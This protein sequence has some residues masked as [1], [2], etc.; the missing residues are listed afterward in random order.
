ME[1]KTSPLSELIP[2][3]PRLSTQPDSLGQ[4]PLFYAVQRDESGA[5]DLAEKLVTVGIDPAQI[6]QFGQTAL[7]YAA[8]AGNVNVG[9]WLVSRGCQLQRRDIYGQTPLF[10]AAR[11]GREKWIRDQLLGAGTELPSQMASHRPVGFEP[12][13]HHE[14]DYPQ[15]LPSDSTGQTPLFYAAREGHIGCVR[16]L[17]EKFPG[18]VLHADTGARTAAWF[19]K[20]RGWEEVV[21]LLESAEKQMRAMLGVSQ[22]G[23]ESHLIH[24]GEHAHALPF[25]VTQTGVPLYRCRLVQTE[26]LAEFESTH[27]GIAQWPKNG[28]SAKRVEQSPV[29]GSISRT[30]RLPVPSKGQST[31]SW[32]NTAKKAL[33]DLVKRPESEIFSRPVD[34]LKDGCTDYFSFITQ[35]MDFGTILNKLKRSEYENPAGLMSD[36]SLVFS[37]CATYNREGSIPRLLAAKVERWLRARLVKDGLI[38]TGEGW[39]SIDVAPEVTTPASGTVGRLSLSLGVENGESNCPVSSPF[40]RDSGSIMITNEE[41]GDMNLD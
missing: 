22:S 12:V 11:E 21:T 17:L 24:A 19:A 33:T 23:F 37:N 4:T 13:A 8:L 30:S 16:A 40:S 3:I 15:P 39:T 28:P 29:K 27:P 35:P 18:S 1:F 25:A 9:H 2:L 31:P 6:D 7:F 41:E 38:T 36:I 10:Y 20:S 14:E 26:N 5:L 32:L 34:P